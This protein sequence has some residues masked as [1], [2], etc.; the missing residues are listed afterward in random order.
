MLQTGTKKTLEVLKRKSNFINVIEDKFAMSIR[1]G[2]LI[3][4]FCKEQVQK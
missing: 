2:K 4:P 3:I 1:W